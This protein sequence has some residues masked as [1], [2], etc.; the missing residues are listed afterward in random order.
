MRGEERLPLRWGLIRQFHSICV[1][2]AAQRIGNDTR[3]GTIGKPCINQRT[4]RIYNARLSLRG[5][6][7]LI[8]RPQSNRC[9]RT[10]YYLPP[11]LRTRILRVR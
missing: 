6:R 5:R 9:A 10:G 4:R 3:Y 2:Y 11:P 8:A 7:L 1:N